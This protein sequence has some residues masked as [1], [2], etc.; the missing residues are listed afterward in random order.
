M[1]FWNAWQPADYKVSIPEGEHKVMITEVH[2]NEKSKSN[3]PMIRIQLRISGVKGVRINYYLVD[4]EFFNA[5]ATQFFDAF[6]IQRGNWNF[7][8]WVNSVA[9]GF[10]ARGKA[11]EN[12]NSYV[13][14]KYLV[15]KNPDIPEA[16][17]SVPDRSRMQTKTQQDYSANTDNTIPDDIPF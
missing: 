15:V 12:G 11:D 10:F 9:T 4:G 14:M 6:G 1:G 7:S 13:D 2:P 8:S 5:K 17:Q 16:P 3:A